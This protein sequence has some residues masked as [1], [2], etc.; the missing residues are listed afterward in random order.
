[1][2]AT[3]SADADS[4]LPHA[5]ST[6]AATAQQVWQGAEDLRQVLLDFLDTKDIWQLW[7]YWEALDQ[8]TKLL[9]RLLYETNPEVGLER[10][11]DGWIRLGRIA[12]AIVAALE[13]F[14]CGD[15]DLGGDEREWMEQALNML[16]L[17]NYNADC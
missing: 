17:L 16:K 15:V 4:V 1:M 11:G 9:G 10:N 14:K 2:P 5:A 8:Q 13:G 6:P 3:V 7:S 12:P